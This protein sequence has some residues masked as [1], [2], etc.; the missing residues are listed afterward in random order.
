MTWMHEPG[1]NASAVSD[2][3]SLRDRCNSQFPGDEDEDY[4]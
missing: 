2:G 3:A 1:S 4:D